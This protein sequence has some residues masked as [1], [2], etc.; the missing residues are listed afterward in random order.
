MSNLNVSSIPS[1]Y[2][3][4]YGLRRSA[5]FTTLKYLQFSYFVLNPS[6]LCASCIMPFITQSPRQTRIINSTLF[7]PETRNSQRS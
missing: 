2:N 4:T 3:I 7:S 5:M 6:L 1:E